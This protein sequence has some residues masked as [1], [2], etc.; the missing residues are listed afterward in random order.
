MANNVYHIYSFSLNN[1][2]ER[3][4]FLHQKGEIKREEGGQFQILLARS[5]TQACPI[6]LKNFNFKGM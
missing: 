3:L 2:Q 1:S 5:C 6:S 4:F